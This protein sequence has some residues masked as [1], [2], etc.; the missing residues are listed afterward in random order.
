MISGLTDGIP[1]LD[2]ELVWIFRVSEV[3]YRLYSHSLR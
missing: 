3:N 1:A 2:T